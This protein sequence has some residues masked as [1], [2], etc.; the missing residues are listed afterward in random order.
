MNQP[1]IIN[2]SENLRERLDQYQ[3]QGR[4]GEPVSELV[5]AEVNKLVC[6]LTERSERVSATVADDGLLSLCAVFRD[7]VRLYVEIERDGATGAAVSRSRAHANDLEVT[8]LPE[9]T[10]ELVLAAVASP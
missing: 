7:D 5:M 3:G 2:I 9:L 4:E 8:T 10:P 1:D 6:W